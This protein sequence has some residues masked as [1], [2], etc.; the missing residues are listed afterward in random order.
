MGER[1]GF[2]ERMEFSLLCSVM[3]GRV[4][5]IVWKCAWVVGAREDLL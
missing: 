3:R 4:F 5:Y 1:T 2:G